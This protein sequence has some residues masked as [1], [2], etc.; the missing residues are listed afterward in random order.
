[1]AL[2]SITI[3][4]IMT[5]ADGSLAKGVRIPVRPVGVFGSGGELIVPRTVWFT[6]DRTTAAYSVTL[7]TTDAADSFVPYEADVP[8]DEHT[9]KTK[10]FDL[11]DDILTTSLDALF[12]LYT[13]QGA[14][15]AAALAVLFGEVD[16]RLDDLENAPPG[17]AVWGGITGDIEDQTDLVDY[18][19]THAPGGSGDMAAATYDPQGI[20]DDAFDRANHTGTQA[21]STITSLVNDLALK[22][23]IASPTFTGTVGGITKS[24]VGLG[25]ADDTSDANKPVSSAQ[26]T[27]LNLKANLASPA[28]TGT[29]TAPTAAPGTNTTQLSTTAFVA[30]AVAALIGTA[31]G[32]LDTLGEIS[33][34]IN[35]DQNLYTTL[36]SAL[37]AKASITYVDTLVADLQL[38]DA[39]LSAIANLSSAA[40]KL[41]YA[42]GVSAWAMTTF[43]AFARTLLDDADAATMRGT[44]GLGSVDN[45][46]DAGKPVSTATQT[47]LDLK[48]NLASPAL[49]GNPTAPTQT[50]G[51]NS[52]RIAT[53]A[54]ADAAIAALIASA[55]G[56]LDTLDELAAAFGDDPNFAATVTTALAGKQPLDADLTAIAGLTSAANKVPYFTGSGTAALA[57]FPSYGRSLAATA[58]LAA[59]QAIL[60]TGTPSSSTYLRGDGTW[61]TPA[62][63][64]T[65]GSAVS[66]GGASRV[67]FEDAS[68]NLAADADFTFD[69]SNVSLGGDPFTE[70]LNVAG[71]IRL[72]S[73]AKMTLKVDTDSSNTNLVLASPS[74]GTATFSCA[75][76]GGGTYTA[77]T[78]GINMASN[79]I[80]YKAYTAGYGDYPN[81]TAHLFE[82]E[83]DLS[84]AGTRLAQFNRAGTMK[85]Y[86]DKDGQGFFNSGIL[87]PEMTAPSAPASNQGY[88]Y[89]DDNGSGKTRLM[90]RFATGAV[91]Q[92][93]IEP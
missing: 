55:P 9:T 66:S 38:A 81:Y 4:G 84:D 43:T 13:A 11:T 28:L 90:V 61:A 62:G 3:A 88:I 39:D 89:L 77:A 29:P 59:L 75:L 14:S 78:Q 6:T 47:A 52:T 60:G 8:I 37:A 45:T 12:N 50:P 74:V 58:N 22:A 25:S 69:G 68:Q 10:R 76:I 40:N 93:A 15:D 53:T 57:D 49:T 5:Y 44:L 21:Q 33:D 36:T 70:R 32:V 23:P 19:D 83:V 91:Q 24:M 42:T 46:S 20:E 92:I 65:V 85:A 1:M 80:K 41:P 79:G 67:L 86:I 48:A 72:G 26:Q 64:M 16:E 56:A 31:P 73:T 18:I 54:Y 35:D 27:A 87:L 51:N 7:R 71:W 2:V 30:A 17:S 34:A 63:G 82:T